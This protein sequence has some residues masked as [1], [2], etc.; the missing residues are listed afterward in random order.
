MAISSRASDIRVAQQLS[1]LASFP[2]LA[3]TLL[4]SFHVINSTLVLGASLAGALL[5]I[6]C[7]ACLLV[8]KLFDIERL[9]TGTKPG[10]AITG[11]PR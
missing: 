1:I 9:V 10:I 5:V 3:L 4:M 2:P 7:A 11:A 8:S 6:D